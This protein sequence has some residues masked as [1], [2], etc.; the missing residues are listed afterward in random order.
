MK[1]LAEKFTL[2]RN[3]L[4]RYLSQEDGAAPLHYY[5]RDNLSVKPSGE[6]ES[7]ASY[8]KNQEKGLM[9]VVAQCMLKLDQGMDK[10]EMLNFLQNATKLTTS[11]S[12]LLC[13]LI[14]QFWEARDRVASLA[15]H[16]QKYNRESLATSVLKL[17]GQIKNK[18]FS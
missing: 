16:A 13:R 6:I 15:E 5:S 2:A 1:T 10:S 11:S 17:S 12:T 9:T 7:E 3:E 18:T 14:H 4:R 8:M